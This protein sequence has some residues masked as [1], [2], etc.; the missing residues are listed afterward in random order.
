MRIKLKTLSKTQGIK[1]DDSVRHR[2]KQLGERRGRTPHWLM[3]KAIETYLDREELYEQ[4][5]REDSDRWDA[6]QATGYAIENDR[7]L[8]WLDSLAAGKDVKCP[9]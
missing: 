5:K 7:A 6:Y 8:A 2:L 3:R 4:E 1:L 9:K